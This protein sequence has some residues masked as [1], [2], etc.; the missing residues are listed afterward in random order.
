[1]NR[2]ENFWRHNMG[3]WTNEAEAREQIKE[4]VAE[5]YQE[6]KEEKKEFESLQTIISFE[7]QWFKYSGYAIR[8]GVLN[9]K[10]QL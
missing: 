10:F 9:S 1:M 6:F 5:Y 8:E 7:V 4:M 3:K 2:L